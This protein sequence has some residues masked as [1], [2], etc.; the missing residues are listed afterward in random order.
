MRFPGL[1]R[2]AFRNYPW[3]WR[4]LRE[5]R[6]LQNPFPPFPAAFRDF[7]DPA[8]P[9]PEVWR[10]CL[11]LGLVVAASIAWIRLVALAADLADGGFPLFRLLPGFGDLDEPAGVIW[12]LACFAGPVFGLL[13]AVGLVHRRRPATLVGPR[14]S[15]VGRDFARG[16]LVAAGILGAGVLAVVPFMQPEGNL[17]TAVWL[18]WLVPGIP[19]LLV[20]VAA[21]ELVFRGYLQQQLAARFRSPLIWLALPSFAFGILHFDQDAFGSNAWLVVAATVVFGLI[22]GDVTARTGN[23]GAAT[24]LHAANN[25]VALFLVGPDGYLTGLALFVLPFHAS[26]ATAARPFLV[27]DL[28][29]LIAAYAFYLGAVR[30][31]RAKRAARGTLPDAGGRGDPNRSS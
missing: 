22:A 9:R 20:Q 5:S 25:F 13:A 19:L 26:D 4:R 30:W 21:E 31:I 28:L 12:L 15:R 2:S 27:M 24:G 29:S 17:A 18:A 6:E 10:T 7:V 8:R 3:R 1:T 11:G 14:G 16:F 23:I